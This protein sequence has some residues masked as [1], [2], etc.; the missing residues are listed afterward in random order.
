MLC[1]VISKAPR[2]AAGLMA[3]ILACFPV[4]AQNSDPDALF[5]QGNSAMR[6]GDFS[7]AAG[8]YRKVT[9]L[10]AGFPEAWFSLGLA[11]EQDRKY[12]DAAAALKRAR[13]LKPALRGVNLFLG[14]AYYRLNDLASAHQALTAQ[15]AQEPKDAAG[16]MW[17]GV[18]ELAED[19]TEAAAAALDR[20]ATLDPK[21]PDIQYHR[22]RAHLLIS[23]NAYQAMFDAAPDSWRVHEVL[24]QADAE[25]YRTE[26]A[27]VEFRLALRDAPNE[28]GLH[29]ELGDAFW[30]DG[31]LQDAEDAYA[32]E[33]KIDP[34]SAVTM[35]K[36][37]SLRVTRDDAEHGAPLL[38]SA[39]ALDPSLIDAHYYLGRGEAA[40]GHDDAAIEQFRS[41]VTGNADEELSMMSWYQLAGLYRRLHR[42]QE[43][44]EALAIFRRMKATKDQRQQ[45]KFENKRHDRHELPH[46]ETVPG[47]SS[48]LP[49]AN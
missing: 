9:E 37:G 32:E 25:A 20:A 17:L 12:D 38:R 43:A 29:E 21:N 36:L 41:A 22:G 14:I 34:S 27:I 10:R 44:A 13:S 1:R 39:L 23:K 28:P 26:D 49:P 16:W 33:L 7:A 4:W 8:A 3:A 15:T 18:V 47:E 2:L 5:N 48:T 24:G 42:T 35:Y 11:L 45:T 30:T 40:L 31:K 46:Q 6:S 19:K